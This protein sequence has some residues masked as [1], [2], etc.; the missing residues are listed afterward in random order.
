MKRIHISDDDFAKAV[1]DSKSY[2]EVCRI[3]GLSPKGGN[4][5]TIRTRIKRQNLSTKHMLGQAINR[6]GTSPKRKPIEYYLTVGS[7][8]N[9]DR[10]KKRLWAAGILDKKCSVCGITEWNRQPAPLQ[11]DHIN[12]YNND[13]RLVN[14]RVLCPNCH[15]QTDTY[16]VKGRGVVPAAG[17]E[18]ANVVF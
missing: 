12:G 4:I 7:N 18:P 13:N 17:L 3:I 2:A 14:L 8:I 11:L 5:K 10:L 9:S 16:S 1:C 15:A 6:G